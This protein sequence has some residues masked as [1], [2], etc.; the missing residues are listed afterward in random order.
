MSEFDNYD[1]KYW[2]GDK[3][4]GAYDMLDELRQGNLLDHS[5]YTFLFDVISWLEAYVLET[6]TKETGDEQ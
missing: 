3:I 2:D 6:K 4:V 5:Q 1:F